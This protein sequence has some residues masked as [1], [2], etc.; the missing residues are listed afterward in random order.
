MSTPSSLQEMSLHE[1]GKANEQTPLTRKVEDEDVGCYR[2]LFGSGAVACLK[3]E[4]E[5]PRLPEPKR[6][7]V[8]LSHN[9]YEL[10][11]C[12]PCVH[13]PLHYFIIDRFPFL[14]W[15]LEY[16]LRWLVADVIAGL[17]VGLMVVPQALAYAKI[18][19]LPL[20]VN[21]NVFL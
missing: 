14:G 15:L 4:G 7:D 1:T 19:N 6:P 5:R 2:A 11:E 18:A 12:L 20:K 16:N 8:P 9:Q 3:G 13:K 21:L 17:T 10:Q